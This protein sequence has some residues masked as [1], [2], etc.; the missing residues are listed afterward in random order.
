MYYVSAQGVDEHMINV[1]S[2]SY[3]SYYLF[4]YASLYCAFFVF[5]FYIATSGML[6]LFIRNVN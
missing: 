6:I 4:T 2:Y 5:L 1:H 3:T